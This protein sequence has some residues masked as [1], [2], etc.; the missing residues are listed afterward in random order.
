[1]KTQP[2]QDGLSSLF[3]FR[4]HLDEVAERVDG[5]ARQQYTTHFEEGSKL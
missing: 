5:V 1:L 3:V 4:A 2:L